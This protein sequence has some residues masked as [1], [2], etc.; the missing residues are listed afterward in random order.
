MKYKVAK[1]HSLVVLIFF[2]VLFC[3]GVY[4]QQAAEGKTAR[5]A[6]MICQILA[7]IITIMP[8]FINR[9]NDQKSIP[10]DCFVDR[11]DTIEY[12]FE[13]L[14]EIVNGQSMDKYIEIQCGSEI[15]IGKTE[16]LNEIRSLL[17]TPK[18]AKDFF[19]KKAFKRYKS[20]YSKIG[21]IYYLEW[22]TNRTEKKI[23]SYP[24]T[25]FRKNVFMIDSVPITIPFE[26]SKNDIIVFTSISKPNIM[27][28]N[29]PNI[30]KPLQHDDI[31]TYYRKIHKSE[32]DDFIL[33]RIMDFSHGNIS[34]IKKIVDSP[35]AMKSFKDNSYEM[36]SIEEFI[37]IGDYQNARVAVDNYSSS[38]D[39]GSETFDYKL[40]YANLMHLENRYDECL[41]ELYKMLSDFKDLKSQ[42]KILERIGHVLKHQSKFDESIEALSK[43]GDAFRTAERSISTD[44]MAYSFYEDEYY[45]D[46]FLEDLSTI[47]TY[48]DSAVDEE[49]FLTYRAVRSAYQEEPNRALSEID[50]AIDYY[51]S[52]SHRRLY[53]C[54]FIKGEVLRHFS[55]YK[56][57]FD[58]YQHCIIAYKFNNDF[59]LYAMASLM[60]Q[61]TNVK[62]KTERKYDMLLSNDEILSVSHEKNIPYIEKLCK[63][64]MRLNKGL[65]SDEKSKSDIV[66]F[67]KYL[68]LIP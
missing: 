39:A 62:A 12:V 24:R 3:V 17:N 52:I 45:Y 1:S 33:D 23:S 16:L 56:G 14:Y 44:I 29:I 31:R 47:E 59:D 15:G 2:V 54:Y 10:L 57:A 48:S 46:K 38:L 49:S 37:K 5:I 58:C 13:R 19:G 55:D 60:M 41:A 64:V 26:V 50:Y 6:G 28:A 30:L 65:L 27:D 11:T 18:S 22:E 34:E 66:Y 68:F 32:I 63:K 20:L 51:K 67:D 8:S 53:N 25:L 4:L 7:F 9:D 21:S 36:Y 35:S 42:E 40:L 61:Y 43:L